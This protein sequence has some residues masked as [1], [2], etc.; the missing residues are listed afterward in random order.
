MPAGKTAGKKNRRRNP[1]NY[2]AYI[3][4]VLKQVHPDL[5]ISGKTIMAVDSLAESILKNLTAKGAAIA[6]TAKK[7][8]LSSRHI[9]GAANLVL[10]DELAKH[11]VSEG[12]KA[13][14]KFVSA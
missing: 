1:P 8:T 4:K 9:Q 5:Q 3:H 2:A 10:P 12:T 14:S 11:A 7:T 13:V 6:K